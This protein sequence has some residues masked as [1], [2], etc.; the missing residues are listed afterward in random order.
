MQTL[1]LNHYPPVIKQI[2][3]MQQIAKAEDIQVS[4]EDVAAEIEKMAKAYGME[5][6]KVSK[7]LGDAQ[8]ESM[9]KDISVQKAVKLV[10][11]NVKERAKAKPKKDKEAAE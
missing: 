8:K 10:M 5:A 2:K 9:K 3:E 1:I 4:D 11:E 7:F 6:E